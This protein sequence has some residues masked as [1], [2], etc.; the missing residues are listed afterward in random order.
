VQDVVE[1]AFDTVD[2]T[3]KDHIAR[4]ARF[5]RPAEPQRLVGDASKAANVLNWNPD[6]SFHEMIR[7]MTEIE[8][9]RLSGEDVPG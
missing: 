9:K 4:D 2:L 5:M 6:V 3:W 1:T 8:L 7:E